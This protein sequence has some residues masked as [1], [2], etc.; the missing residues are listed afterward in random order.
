MALRATGASLKAHCDADDNKQ[1]L[2]AD[3]VLVCVFWDRDH[4]LACRCNLRLTQR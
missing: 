3:V 1:M 4:W 2:Y